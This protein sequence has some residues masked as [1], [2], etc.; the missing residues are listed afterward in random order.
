MSFDHNALTII[1]DLIGRAKKAGAD[2]ADVIFAEGKSSSMTQRMGKSEHLERSES[3][4]IGLRV[5]VGSRQAI[6]SSSDIS[7]SAL[8]ALIER[9]MAMA[10]VVPEDP[11]SGI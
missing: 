10:K 5:F 11:Y 8:D 6:V 7:L 4:D 9:G 2:S 3:I 1:T